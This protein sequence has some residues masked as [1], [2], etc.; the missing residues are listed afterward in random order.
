VADGIIVG[1]AVIKKIEA[2]LAKKD[3]IARVSAFVKTLRQAI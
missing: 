2:N 1:S 3:L